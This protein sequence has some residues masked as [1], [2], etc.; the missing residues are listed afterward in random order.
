[1]LLSEWT[2]YPNDSVSKKKNIVNLPNKILT[3][4]QTLILNKGL[5]FYPSKTK[6]NK[7]KFFKDSEEFIRKVRLMEYHQYSDKHPT[8]ETPFMKPQSSNCTPP[9]GRNVHVDSFVDTARKQCNFFLISNH[10][11]QISNINNNEKH[12]LNELAKDNSVTIKEADKG[13]AIVLF[14]T[15]DYINGCENLVSDT[16]NYKNVQPKT[17]KEFMSEAKNII[18]NLHGTCAVFLKN[19]LPDQPKP[20]VFYGIPK[21]HKLPEVIKTAMECRNITNENLSDQTAI[22]IA[23]E[24]NILPPF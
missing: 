13:G 4:E 8:K 2:P 15:C 11:T 5:S 10:P 19:T 3:T 14:N 7:I 1:M 9:S 23:I 22:D 18:S 16:R 17:L 21:I 24:H 6:I 20:A 12:S